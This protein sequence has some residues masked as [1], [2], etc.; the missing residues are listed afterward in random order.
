MQGQRISA[1]IPS[2]VSVYLMLFVRLSSSVWVDNIKSHFAGVRMVSAEGGASS[3][4]V[5]K[6]ENIRL[7]IV[8]L[9]FTPYISEV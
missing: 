4:T 3:S 1:Q 6:I 9:P 7:Q 8:R 5:S 2:L